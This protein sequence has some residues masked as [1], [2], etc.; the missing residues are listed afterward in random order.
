MKRNRR[1]LSKAN[2]TGE[3]CAHCGMKKPPPDRLVIRLF[4]GYLCPDHDKTAFPADYKEAEAPIAG[5]QSPVTDVSAARPGLPTGL[6]REA[7]LWS[8][9]TLYIEGV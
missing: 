3:S 1:R 8:E 7:M 4:S 9:A 2:A 6:I 5:P